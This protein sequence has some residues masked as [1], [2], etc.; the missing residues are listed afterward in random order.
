VKANR[1][2]FVVN[3]D[4][5]LEGLRRHARAQSVQHALIVSTHQPYPDELREFQRLVRKAELLTFADLLT[6]EEMSACDERARQEMLTR[7]ATHGRRRCAAYYM[8][9]VRRFKNEKVCAK[10]GLLRPGARIF[11][12]DGLGIDC[13]VWKSAGSKPLAETKGSVVRSSLISRFRRLLCGEVHLLTGQMQDQRALVLGSIRRISLAAGVSAHRITWPL[14]WRLTP[15]TANA[16]AL[17]WAV[18]AKTFR[19]LPP[20]YTSVHQYNLGLSMFAACC[21]QTLH[22]LVDGH[23]P[24]N[25]PASYIDLFGEGVFVATNP[26][27]A[28]WFR[29]HGRQVVP[30]HWFQATPRF[31]RCE[32]STIRRIMLVLNHAGDWTAL[33]ERCDTDR[34]VLAFLDVAK[35]WPTLEFIIRIHPTMATPEH[36]G[37]HAIRRIEA[38]VTGCGLPNLEL[39]NRSLEEDL[40]RGDLYIS[41]YSQVLIDAWQRGKLGAAVNL[42]RRRSFMSD[43]AY[44]GFPQAASNC[45]L[46]ALVR[47]MV[48]DPDGAV[49]RQNRAVTRFN[50][51]AAHWVCHGVVNIDAA[52]WKG[53]AT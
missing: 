11:H 26:L 9:R 5:S 13:E 33:I 17:A 10:V 53:S 31:D 32:Q 28:E 39:S 18:G 19:S 8:A 3:Q 7:L 25:Y 52:A 41:E 47:G 38:L 15:T 29:Q 2:V 30:G 20:I 24:S 42:T 45:D 12:M 48:E 43:Y 22:I 35:Q 14:D 21:G 50:A 6:E 51:V 40:G 46:A 34:L 49:T 36:E 1:A 4:V 37:V 44:L 27:S 16:A 23:H